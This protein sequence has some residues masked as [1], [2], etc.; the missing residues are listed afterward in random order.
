MEWWGWYALKLA[1]LEECET[2]EQPDLLAI[3]HRLSLSPFGF[4][5]KHTPPSSSFVVQM[6]ID[7]W[8][9][10]F[11]RGVGNLKL[12]S[13]L[14]VPHHEGSQENHLENCR[15]N[16]LQGECIIFTITNFLLQYLKSLKPNP[17]LPQ[18]RTQQ[19]L[20]QNRELL[21]HIAA[22]GGYHDPDRPNLTA[23]SIGIAPQVFILKLF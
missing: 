20:Q 9:K 16:Y 4:K 12:K 2:F 7:L 15:S 19:L 14:K 21:E 8:G 6:C 23:A 18:A 5:F 3:F 13:K 17:F 11:H 10:T 22:L 1:G